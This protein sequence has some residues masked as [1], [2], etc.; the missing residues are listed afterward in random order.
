VCSREKR[1]NEGKKGEKGMKKI[2]LLMSIPL[3]MLL[4]TS[5]S[6]ENM[7][8][9]LTPMQLAEL[10]IQV[11]KKEF[12]KTETLAEFNITKMQKAKKWYGEAKKWY[13]EAKKWYDEAVKY[14]KKMDESL[15]V[16][17]SLNKTI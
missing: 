10:M 3:G 4:A 16:S 14:E 1:F 13:D 9:N 17:E 12:S 5:T 7:D 8:N 2:I 11:D 6:Q 15:K